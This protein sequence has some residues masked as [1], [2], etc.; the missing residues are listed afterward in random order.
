M[1]LRD[2]LIDQ[3]TIY[4]IAMHCNVNGHNKDWYGQTLK[5]GTIRVCWGPHRQAHQYAVRKGGTA[6]LQKVMTEKLAKGYVMQDEY[7]N[8]MWMSQTAAKVTGMKVHEVPLV[9]PGG[10]APTAKTE[11]VM[12]DLPQ[13][14]GALTYDF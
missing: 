10:K 8:G 7:K 3:D 6:E 11:S 13:P 1:N 12:K 9:Y 2:A 5:N 4:C 14:K